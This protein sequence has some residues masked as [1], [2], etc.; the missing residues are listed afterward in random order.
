MAEIKDF[1]R[2]CYSHIDCEECPFEI[3]KVGACSSFM[4]K[5]TEEAENIITEW[6]KE[7]PQ[8]TYAMDFFEKFPN[9]REF[10]DGIPD[11][12][13]CD[14]YGDLRCFVDNCS[15]GRDCAICWNEVIP[16]A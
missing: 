4:Y 7:H 13:A 15:G 1:A 6:C 2:M 16:D 11:L 14:I 9:A 10:T 8:K 5:H 12:P 3:E